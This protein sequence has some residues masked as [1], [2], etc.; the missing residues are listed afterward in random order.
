MTDATAISLRS[1]QVG[2]VFRIQTGIDLTDTTDIIVRWA[3]PDGTT[4]ERTSV[5]F[6][7]DTP[8]DILYTLQAGDFDDEGVFPL[9]I[10]AQWTGGKKIRSDSAISISVEDLEG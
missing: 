10:E 6:D 7:A 9:E 8:T 5:P 2:K 1:G 4:E 3:L